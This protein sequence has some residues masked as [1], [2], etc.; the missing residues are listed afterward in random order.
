MD[1]VKAALSARLL[2]S[3]PDAGKAPTEF[4]V[5]KAGW[6]QTE[7]GNFLFDE[8]A[9][10]AVMEAYRAKGLDKVQID[11]EHQSLQPPPGGGPADKP[12][13]G[14]FKPEVRNGELW[15]VEL[16][17]SARAA[18]MLAP[19]AGA[20]EYRYFSP[21]LFFDEDTRRVTR[22]KNI[23]LTND[24]AMDEIEPLAA[25]TALPGKDSNMPCENCTA[26][27][28]KVKEMEEKCSALTAQLSAFQ[29]K[30]AD[31]DNDKKAAMT[32]LTAVQTRLCALTGQQT[33]AAALGVIEAWKT[34]AA[35]ADTLIAEKAQLEVA[36]LTAE[37]GKILD[38]ATKAGKLPPALKTFEEKAALAFGGGKL[39]KE[40]VEFLRAKWGAAGVAPLVS[41]KETSSRETATVLT[42]ADYEMGKKLNTDM[43]AFEKWKIEKAEREAKERAARS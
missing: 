25:A 31:G 2:M 11:Y 3:I 16:S 12:A 43:V 5:L 7:K 19:A 30:D 28:A 36:A 34:K 32:A 33:E 13:A 4:R 20:P 14:W 18:S 27:S 37:M 39:T 26:L 21:I 8:E 6:N 22:L 23:A 9:A 35:Q 42:A 38:E 29:K 15:A 10:N 24:P 41:T 40:G 17:W 1:R